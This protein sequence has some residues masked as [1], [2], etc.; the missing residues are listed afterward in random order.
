MEVRQG[1]LL[2]TRM[3]SVLPALVELP[4]LHYFPLSYAR[5]LVSV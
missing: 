1:N 2:V 4:P 5:F 3:P